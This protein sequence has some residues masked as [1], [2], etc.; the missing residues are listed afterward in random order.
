[1]IDAVR[2]E[3]LLRTVPKPPED[4]IPRGIDDGECDD[5]EKRTGIGRTRG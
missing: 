4:V 2:I 3:E 1:M 5:F